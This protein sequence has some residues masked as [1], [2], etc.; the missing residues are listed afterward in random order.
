V[1][2]LHRIADWFYRSRRKL[3]TAAVAALA[4]M[5]FVHVIFGDNGFL[6]YQKKKAQYRALDQDIQKLQKENDQLAE[7]IKNLKSDPATI[8]KEARE[9]LRYA[10]PGEVIYT[11]P[12]PAAQ[13]PAAPAAAAQNR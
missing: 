7:R 11:Y 2:L 6:A 8:E 1:K 3:A 9:Q 4:C 5:M 12:D 10:R 13:R